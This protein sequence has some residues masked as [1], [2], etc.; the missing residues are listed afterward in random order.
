M[1]SINFFQSSSDVLIVFS[2]GDALLLKSPDWSIIGVPFT[3]VP[4]NIDAAVSCDC[5]PVVY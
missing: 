4:D 2:C 3:T 5:D 1:F